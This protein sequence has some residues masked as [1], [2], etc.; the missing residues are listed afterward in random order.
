MQF[1]IPITTAFQND[2]PGFTWAYPRILA[3]SQVKYLV[4]GLNLF[5]GGGNNLGPGKNPFY[6]V[7][8]NGSRVLT[9]F[10]YDSYMEGVRWKINA[11]GPLSEMEETD[12]A[13]AG[14]ART[15]WVS[16]RRGAGDGIDR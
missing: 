12:S 3:G 14:V 8:P 7:G 16:L 13:A 9:W 15:K 11:R 4:T 5:I 10:A 1:G 2:V 6:C